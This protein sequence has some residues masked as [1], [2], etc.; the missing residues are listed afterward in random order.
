MLDVP[1]NRRVERRRRIG[2]R[3]TD[4][5]WRWLDE[6]IQDDT[7][8]GDGVG[9]ADHRVRRGCPQRRGGA[10]GVASGSPGDRPTE[11]ARAGSQGWACPSILQHS[12]ARGQPE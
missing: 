8:G 7:A 6:M 1:D 2:T 5:E 11:Q 10:S 4:Q 9:H 3:A 12:S